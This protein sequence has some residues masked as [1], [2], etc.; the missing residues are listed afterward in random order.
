MTDLT[1]ARQDRLLTALGDAPF[2]AFLAASPANVHHATG[3][4]SVAT[5]VFRQHQMAALVAPPGA[6]SAAIWCWR[7][8]RVATL[9]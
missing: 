6:T 3:Y 5:R 2:D 9:R 8:T 7:K 4:R 1:T